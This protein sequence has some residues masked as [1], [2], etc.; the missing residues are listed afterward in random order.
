MRRL[1][2]TRLLSQHL[3]PSASFIES[4]SLFVIIILHIHRSSNFS[5]EWKSCKTLH[6]CSTRE[7]SSNTI[8]ENG[9]NHNGKTDNIRQTENVGCYTPESPDS[10]QHGTTPTGEI[11]YD[12]GDHCNNE[13]ELSP[14]DD[15]RGEQPD[16]EEECIKQMD[17]IVEV[18]R[19]NEIMKLKVLSSIISI[20][21][22]NPSRTEWAKDTAVKYY[23]KTLDEVQALSSSAIWRGDIARDTLEPRKRS[24]NS[25][26][27]HRFVDHDTKIDELISQISW[28]SKRSRKHSSGNASDDKINLDGTSNKKWRVFESEMP[29]YTR[30]EDARRNG[31]KDW[32][33]TK[34]PSS[35]CLEW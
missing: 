14:E 11:G 7:R 25:A 1:L 31:N 5:Y 17:N 16:I 8:G 9:S 35:L 22:L 3:T 12:E 28:D 21:D 24:A 18:F 23:A 30:E 4:N 6:I 26:E 20:L 15:D 13:G 2:S 32:R 19:S 29:W 34:N 27:P 10:R 33:I